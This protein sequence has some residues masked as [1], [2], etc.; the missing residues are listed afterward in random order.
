MAGEP[1]GRLMSSIHLEMEGRVSPEAA[2]RPSL[3][4]EEDLGSIHA[5]IAAFVDGRLGYLSHVLLPLLCGVDR[6][7]AHRFHSCKFSQLWGHISQKVASAQNMCG[8]RSPWLLTRRAQQLSTWQW[9]AGDVLPGDG[10]RTQKPCRFN[11]LPGYLQGRA[12]QSPSA[13]LYSN[14]KSTADC[15]DTSVG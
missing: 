6:P 9:L 3:Q 8:F 13:S 12:A 10:S 5:W 11:T 15:R 2:K 14:R 7:H 1:A 4:T